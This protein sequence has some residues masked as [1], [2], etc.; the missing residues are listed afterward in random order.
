MSD[1]NGGHHNNSITVIC[2]IA[3]FETTDYDVILPSHVIQ[4][5]QQLPD[6]LLLQAVMNYSP[7]DNNQETNSPIIEEEIIEDTRDDN[8]SALC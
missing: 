2:A 4:E 1:V 8:F 6:N 5:I 7:T 3:D